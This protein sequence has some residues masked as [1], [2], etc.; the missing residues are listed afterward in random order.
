M[1]A[2]I[3]VYVHSF[4][5]FQ[6]GKVAIYEIP[7][8]GVCTDMRV[9]NPSSCLKESFQEFAIVLHFPVP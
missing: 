3:L 5:L 8:I 7:I 2:D 1:Y 9:W 4:I 6:S